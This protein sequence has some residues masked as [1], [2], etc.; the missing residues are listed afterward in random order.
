MTIPEVLLEIEMRAPKDKTLM[1]LTREQD[2]EL[3]EWIA[4]G[5]GENT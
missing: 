4:G 2:D 3:A 1:G 5:Y